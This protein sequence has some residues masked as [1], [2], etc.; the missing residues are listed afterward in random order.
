LAGRSLASQLTS[1]YLSHRQAVQA[2]EL[3]ET[4]LESEDLL[5]ETAAVL[6]LESEYGATLDFGGI[7]TSQVLAAALQ[8][9]PDEVVP[10]PLPGQV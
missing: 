7:S 3:P 4:Q 10:P 6:R 5:R 2:L 8:H 9:T 1:V